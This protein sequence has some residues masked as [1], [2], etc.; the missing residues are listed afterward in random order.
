[1]IEIRPIKTE[2]EI[3][4]VR[5]LLDEY[6]VWL[7]NFGDVFENYVFEIDNLINYYQYGKILILTFNNEIVGCGCLLKL[8]TY[9]FMENAKTLYKSFGF[10]EIAPY[11]TKLTDKMKFFEFQLAI[12]N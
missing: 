11:K 10:T 3:L 9:E 2:N 4:Q 5:K 1:V 7:L 6:S 12:N 8:D